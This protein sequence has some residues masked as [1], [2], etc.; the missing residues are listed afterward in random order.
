[1]KM[2]CRRNQMNTN[3]TT[4]YKMKKKNRLAIETIQT[5]NTKNSFLRKC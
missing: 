3:K 4:L 2:T 5:V 1:M